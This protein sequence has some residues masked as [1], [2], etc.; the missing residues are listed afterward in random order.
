KAKEIPPASTP[1]RK[2]RPNTP[3]DQQGQ[4]EGRV[5]C[6]P[7]SPV[8]ILEGIELQNEPELTPGIPQTPAFSPWPEEEVRG[9][10]SGMLP[11]SNA[12]TSVHVLQEPQQ[13]PSPARVPPAVPP[14]PTVQL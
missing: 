7:H 13:S 1:G 14:G 10:G 5:Q 6:S 3:Q 11:P 4:T 12:G 8:L 9:Q 2:Q